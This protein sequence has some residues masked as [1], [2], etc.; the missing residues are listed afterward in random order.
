MGPSGVSVERYLR[1]ARFVLEAAFG[2]RTVRFALA[3]AL[4][5]LLRSDSEAASGPAVGSTL[6]IL[7]RPVSWLNSMVRFLKKLW[8]SR[9]SMSPVASGITAH[10]TFLTVVLPTRTVGIV[11]F[12]P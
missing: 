10:S 7:S 3:A 11:I 4:G 8:P 5:L 12:L 2:W 6:L 9:G 1:V